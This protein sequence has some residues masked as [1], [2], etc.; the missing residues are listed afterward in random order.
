MLILGLRQRR[1]NR[2]EVCSTFPK[3]V[4]LWGYY[5]NAVMSSYAE[6][7]FVLDIYF[8]CLQDNK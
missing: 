4:I 1:Y 3:V 5:E 8:Y 7:S 6:A 2:D